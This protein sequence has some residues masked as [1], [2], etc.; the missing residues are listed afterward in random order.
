MALG[1]HGERLNHLRRQPG[2]S[3]YHKP[4]PPGRRNILRGAAW[5]PRWRGATLASGTPAGQSLQF[6]PGHGHQAPAISSAEKKLAL[7]INRRDGKQLPLW[8][9]SMGGAGGEEEGLSVKLWHPER[10]RRLSA[11]GQPSTRDGEMRAKRLSL[12]K[13]TCYSAWGEKPWQARHPPYLNSL[14][15]T[16]IPLH[17]GDF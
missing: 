5:R 9:H 3:L 12:Y 4:A 14:A 8:A 17:G 13:A 1:G 10:D 2:G 7:K 6:S 11:A 15:G 16:G